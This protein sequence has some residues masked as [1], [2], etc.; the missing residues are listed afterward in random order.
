[1]LKRQN[2]KGGQLNNRFSLNV[3]LVFYE[4]SFFIMDEKKRLV[5]IV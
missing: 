1:M 4:M 5:A 3:V 2:S